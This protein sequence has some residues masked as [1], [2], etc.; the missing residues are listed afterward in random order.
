MTEVK[1][2]RVYDEPD[3]SDGYRV[4][5]DRLWPRGVAK[6][7]MQVDLWNKDIAPSI[8]LRKW[9]HENLDNNWS[10]FEE[11][12]LHELQTSPAVDAFLDKIKGEKTVTLVFGAKNAVKNHALVLQNYLISRLN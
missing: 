8:A 3:E 7:K 6:S 2:K 10:G 4:F 12:Y 9:F 1:I 5:V 11:K